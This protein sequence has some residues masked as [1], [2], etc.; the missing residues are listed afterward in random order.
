MSMLMALMLDDN[1]MVDMIT[2]Q[3]EPM[4]EA[5]AEAEPEDCAFSDDAWSICNTDCRKQL[6]DDLPIIMHPI[7][8]NQSMPPFPTLE[9]SRNRTLI[10]GLNCGENDDGVLLETVACEDGNCTK[11]E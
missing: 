9:K 4:P 3:A 5:E 11:G 10:E 2:D 1:V 6:G 8:Q 7:N